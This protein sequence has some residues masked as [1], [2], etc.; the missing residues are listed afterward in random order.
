MTSA[1]RAF[2]L[3]MRSATPES[4]VQ[5][6]NFIIPSAGVVKF[7]GT[8]PYEEVPAQIATADVCICPLPE[9]LEWKVSS[10]LKVF[11]YLASAKPMILTPIPAHRDLVPD[12]GFVVWTAGAEQRDFRRALLAAM[13]GHREMTAHAAAGPALV[14]DRFEW[15]TQAR[16]LSGHL[17]RRRSCGAN[18]S[19]EGDEL[20]RSEALR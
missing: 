2:S 6:F 9:R 15:M 13:A 16:I 5:G 4:E 1:R 20:A 12:S 10:P 14:R 11:E 7:L 18:R 17:K 8:V 3:P 19:A